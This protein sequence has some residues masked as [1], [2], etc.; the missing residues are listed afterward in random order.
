MQIIVQN[1]ATHYYEYGSGKKTIVFLHG[2]ADDGQSFKEQATRLKGWR[3]IAVDLP[4]F[5]KSESPKT[6]WG[7]DDY[8]LF[9]SEV[10]RKLELSSYVLAGHS[11][12]GAIAIRAISLGLL[13]PKKL[14]LLSSAGIRRPHSFRNTALKVIAKSGKV[15]LHLTPPK[16]KA[17]IKQR[18]YKKIGSDYLVAEHMQATFKKVVQ[19]DVL[20]DAHNVHVPTI[21]IYGSEDHDTP[22]AYGVLFAE[23]ISGAV[24]HV[25]ERAGHFVHHDQPDEVHR[26]IAGFLK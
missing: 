17:R 4:G 5:G 21:L 2:W 24:L 14:L 6:V 11:N 3:I 22:Q 25:I 12:G 23:A 18:F 19:H 7:L 15:I 10:T 20:E 16:S 9:V 8:A 26:V 1:L 13:Q